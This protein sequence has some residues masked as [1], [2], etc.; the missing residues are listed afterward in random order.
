MLRHVR[1][2]GWEVLPLS[3]RQ[4]VALKT[5]KWPS[6]ANNLFV[7]GTSMW[8]QLHSAVITA[9]AG[10]IYHY[11]VAIQETLPYDVFMSE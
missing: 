11:M 7:I 3:R 10:G 4:L 1:E 9:P 8:V 2:N 5:S 6:H